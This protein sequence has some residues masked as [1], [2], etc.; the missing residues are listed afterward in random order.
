MLADLHPEDLK[1]SRK[2]TQLGIPAVVVLISGRPL[3]VEAELDESNAFVDAWLPGSA[4]QGIDD[5][6]FGE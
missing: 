5:V 6:I 2:V 3:V 1:A 4:G